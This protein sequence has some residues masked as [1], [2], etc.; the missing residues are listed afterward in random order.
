MKIEQYNKC[1][2][3]AR[4]VAIVSE[5]LLEV[6]EIDERGIKRMFIESG[7]GSK[8]F[9][10]SH[11]DNEYKGISRQPQSIQVLLKV[12]IKMMIDYYQAEIDAL[13]KEF[14]II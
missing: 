10:L 11:N 6:K 2:E 3:I 4:K 8:S 12:T 5:K 1:Q 7:G 13:E 14:E 9:D